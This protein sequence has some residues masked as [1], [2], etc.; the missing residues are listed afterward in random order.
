M[1]ITIKVTKILEP[2]SGVSS[3]IFMTNKN[4]YKKYA[5]LFG[6]INI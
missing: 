1:E 6:Y 3:K 2:Q 5:K 4:G